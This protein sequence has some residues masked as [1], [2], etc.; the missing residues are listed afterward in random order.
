MKCV[1]CIHKGLNRR[2]SDVPSPRPERRRRGISHGGAAA[3]GLRQLQRTPN[4]MRPLH[5]LAK[6]R[7]KTNVDIGAWISSMDYPDRGLNM[8]AQTAPTIHLCNLC[9]PRVSKRTSHR[10]SA[11]RER[12]EIVAP[13]ATRV[14][15]IR[16]TFSVRAHART[17]RQIAGATSR[18]RAA[19]ESRRTRAI[20]P[21]HIRAFTD[22]DVRR[23][24]SEERV[25]M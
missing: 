19:R 6:R 14:I 4:R 5:R 25:H 8:R 9:I 22:A 7:E 10:R 16:V 18:M 21:S 12:A 2:R 17:H 3:F 24:P 11:Q 13:R 15:T 23:R 1:T 20:Q